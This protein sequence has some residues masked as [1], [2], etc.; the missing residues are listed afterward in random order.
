MNCK[1]FHH[2]LNTRDIHNHTLPREVSTHM[3]ACRECELLFAGD[4]A[5]E[6]DIKRAFALEDLPRGLADRVDATLEHETRRKFPGGLNKPAGIALASASLLAGLLILVL[7]F[8]GIFP[9]SGTFK[10]LNQISRQA[11][12]DH[13]KG[14]R[15]ITF[16]AARAEQALAFMTQ[17]LGF[18]VLLP[19]LPLNAVLL[20]GRLCTLG[21]CKAAYFVIQQQGQGRAVGSL[22]IMNTDHLAFDMPEGSRFTTSLKGCETRVW[23]DRGQV[24]AMVF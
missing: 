11:V 3:A 2:W 7:V 8:T 1:E 6:R 12:T 16:E 10:D 19:D 23:R 13:L 18:K 9:S 5:L 15:R 4:D 17:K 20:G 14:D 21:D 24:Y 22:F